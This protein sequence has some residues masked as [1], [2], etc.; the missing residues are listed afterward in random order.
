MGQRDQTMK[1]DW[2]AEQR[3]VAVTRTVKHPPGRIQKFFAAPKGTVLLILVALM[4]IA[5]FHA[6]DR[7]GV[8]NVGIAAGTALLVDLAIGLV[9]GQKRLFSDGGLVTGVIIGLVLNPSAPHAVVFL[10]ALVAMAAKHVLKTG[11]KPWLNPAAV[12]LLFSALAL[13][14]GQSWWGDLADL[15]VVCIL[16]LVVGGYL[17]VNRINKFPQVLSFLGTYFVILTVVA[18]LHWGHAAFTPGDALRT[19]LINSALFMAFFMLTDPPTSPG[20][21]GDQVWFGV[22]AAAVGTVTYLL[23]GGLTY[24]L[25]G[26]L[27]ANAWKAWA[28]RATAKSAVKQPVR[29]AT[30]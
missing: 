3:E 27:V 13:H 18:Y 30:S 28:N 29:R 5:A 21:Y 2:Q 6:S 4:V 16:F 20:R 15:P 9:R 19:P 22:I 12:G 25:V 11:R 26:L 23:F 7:T 1:R 10:T 8:V 24:W 17:M 14:T